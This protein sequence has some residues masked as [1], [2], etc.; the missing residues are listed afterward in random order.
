[1]HAQNNSNDV[2]VY[3]ICQ[4]IQDILDTK[5][6][7]K[8]FRIDRLYY[9]ISQLKEIVARTSIS[10]L[11]EISDLDTR[12]LLRHDASQF[13]CELSEEKNELLGLLLN[14]LCKYNQNNWSPRVDFVAK[15]HK[16][17]DI[18]ISLYYEIGL[19]LTAEEQN[20]KNKQQLDRCTELL[21]E[22][23]EQ[24]RDL[25]DAVLEVEGY[26]TLP[27]DTELK[28]H[29]DTITQY[30]SH[31][32]KVYRITQQYLEQGNDDS[33]KA[34]RTN[35]LEQLREFRSSIKLDEISS[36]KSNIMRLN[37]SSSSTSRQASTRV[38]TLQHN[39]IQNKSDIEVYTIC[40]QIQDI[41]DTKKRGEYLRIDRLYYHISR[42]KEIVTSTPI[43]ALQEIS[44]LDTRILLQHDASQFHCEL[45]QEE[46][47]LLI[48]LLSIVENYLQDNRRVE[49]DF[50]SALS[51]MYE[52]IKAIPQKA[53]EVVQPSSG[54]KAHE[55]KINSLEYP[56][57][58]Y[59]E[60]YTKAVE[61]HTEIAD[62][63][64][65]EHLSEQTRKV[66]DFMSRYDDQWQNISRLLENSETGQAI[67]KLQAIF[68][69]NF[70]AEL[71][72]IQGILKSTVKL[73]SSPSNVLGQA[74]TEA[75]V[76]YEAIAAI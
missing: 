52:F 20:K 8:Y 12:I 17:S 10:A 50:N 56:L 73:I 34:Q 19:L 28:P 29:Y 60:L 26:Q 40:Q 75:P 24:Y 36:I 49:V 46:E 37:S 45:S 41:L 58:Q 71:S 4:Q 68:T 2:V 70:K 67:E 30:S 3:I 31:Y 7:G 42:L 54:D 9:H 57:K 35:I 76:R 18:Y 25:M 43:S 63:D 64:S 5:K 48:S 61:L 66:W 38:P 27:Q 6:R 11:Q 21:K 74:S 65:C 22:Y 53:S 39:G 47:R 23:D 1:M 13:H 51:Q 33:I 59:T 15:L 62:S 14:I 55:F 69:A 72:E 16:L 44:D 32:E